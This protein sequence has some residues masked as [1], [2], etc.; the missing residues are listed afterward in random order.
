VQEKGKVREKG[1][2]KYENYDLSRSNPIILRDLLNKLRYYWTFFEFDNFL[3][4]PMIKNGYTQILA[5][6]A[7]T[8]GSQLRQEEN[9]TN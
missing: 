2:V 3:T 5:T 8:Q 6:V 9:K 4:F 1:E 7:S